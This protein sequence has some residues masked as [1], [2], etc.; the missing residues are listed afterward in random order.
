MTTKQ[1]KPVYAR[2]IDCEA[3]DSFYDTTNLASRQA[4][5]GNRVE[6]SRFPPPRPGYK[7]RVRKKIANLKNNRIQYSGTLKLLFLK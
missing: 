4:Y 6:S 3:I 5:A 1:K 7:I 2:A